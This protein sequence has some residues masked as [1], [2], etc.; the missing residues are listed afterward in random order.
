MVSAEHEGQGDNHGELKANRH[1]VR[2]GRLFPSV[3]I[4]LLL[5]GLTGSVR[6][7]QVEFFDVIRGWEY[8]QISNPTTLSGLME[9]WESLS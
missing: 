5:T 1:F 9:R 7:Q 8:A 6:A 2:P 4:C 3:A